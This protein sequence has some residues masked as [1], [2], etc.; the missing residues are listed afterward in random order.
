MEDLLTGFHKVL[1]S[2]GRVYLN[3]SNSAYGGKI[4][5]VDT[6]IAEIAEGVGFNIVELRVARFTK[7]SGQQNLHGQLR[8]SVTVMEKV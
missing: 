5:E 7:S 2:K 8:E 3:V 6:I 4:C 1:K